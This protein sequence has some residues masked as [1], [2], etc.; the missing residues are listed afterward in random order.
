MIVYLLI[1]QS[2]K[3]YQSGEKNS[4]SLPCLSGGVIL[5]MMPLM[6]GATIADPKLTMGTEERR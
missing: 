3:N 5:D 2:H 4:L 6:I 1:D